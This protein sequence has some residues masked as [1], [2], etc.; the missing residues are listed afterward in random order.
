MFVYTYKRYSNLEVTVH[1]TRFKEDSL[2]YIPG[3]KAIQEGR[4]IVLT[5]E[6]AAMNALIEN[7]EKSKGEDLVKSA[8]IVH[9]DL[10]KTNYY[11]DGKFDYDS[12]VNSLPKSLILLIRMIL[13]GTSLSAE[14]SQTTQQISMSLSQLIKF[15]S[16]KWKTT[17]SSRHSLLQET[18]LPVY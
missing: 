16:I 18:P 17:L 13:E 14:I 2:K 7:I 8:K 12:Q 15:N 4:N 9:Q 3:L 10:F 1:I 5:T 6:E 11:F